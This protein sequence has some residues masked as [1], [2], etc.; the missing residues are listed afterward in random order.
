LINVWTLVLKELRDANRNRWLWLFGVVFTVL[1]I[2]LAWVG[3]DD[4]GGYRVSNF[5]R[6]GASLVNLTLLVLPLMGLLL[7]AISLATD[8][9]RGTLVYLLAQP[10][11]PVEV[12]VAKYL[13]L[14]MALWTILAWGFGLGGFVIAWHG[15]AVN[16]LGY[17][18][19]MAHAGLLALVSLGL[20]ILLSSLVDR[21]THALGLALLAWLWFA[22]LSDLSLIGGTIA[23]QLPADALLGLTLLNPLQVFKLS[24]L[25]VLGGNLDSLGP[26]GL[27]A[28]S[29]YGATLP[30]VLGLVQLAWA[31]IPAAVALGLFYHRRL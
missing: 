13:G 3:L 24:A 29:Q 23:L 11:T 12:F 18:A 5:G 6:V 14:T 20:G 8:R 31:I 2:T 15:S 7:G 16:A 10:V 17:F 26:V 27:Y 4:L 30:F 9:E 28:L 25:L 19:V 1:S 21:V 22:V